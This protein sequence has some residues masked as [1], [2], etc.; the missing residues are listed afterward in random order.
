MGPEDGEK[1][2]VGMDGKVHGL[3]GPRVIDSSIIPLIVTGNLNACTIMLAEKLADAV[4]GR[5]PLTPEDV[6]VFVNPD[7]ETTQ[8]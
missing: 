3:D 8:R 7:W 6:P 5:D 1:T 2:V 4:R